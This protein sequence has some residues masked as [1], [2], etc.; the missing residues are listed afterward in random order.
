MTV[1]GNLMVIGLVEKLV[2]EMELWKAILVGRCDLESVVLPLGYLLA[3][4]WGH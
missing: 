2:Q 4:R 3:Q 1:W